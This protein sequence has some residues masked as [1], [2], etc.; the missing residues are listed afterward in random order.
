MLRNVPSER[1]TDPT[2]RLGESYGEGAQERSS[3]RPKKPY[4]SFP[5]T[6]HSNGQWCKKING[7][8]LYFGRWGEPHAALQNYLAQASRLMSQPEAKENGNLTLQMIADA[9]LRWNERREAS[10]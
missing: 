1:T 3:V 8:V 10:P 5:L 7:R 4:P 2:T 6:A 9:F